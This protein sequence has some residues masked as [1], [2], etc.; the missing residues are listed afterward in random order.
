[1]ASS[2]SLTGPYPT[3]SM[4][5]AILMRRTYN[6]PLNEEGTKFETFEETVDR[7]IDHQKWLWERAQGDSLFPDQV[8]EL[9]ELKEHFMHR[10]VA[11]A[12]RTLW[13]GGTELAKRRESSQ[14][15]CLGKETAFITSEGVRTFEDCQD[16]DV[17]TVLSH[18]GAWRKAVVRCYGQQQLN[19]V[20]LRRTRSVQVIRATANH[21]WILK[22]GSVTDALRTGQH[23]AKPVSKF[24][25]WVYEEAPPAERLYWAYGFVY[26]D[27]T[28]VRNLAGEPERSM[29]RMCGPHKNYVTRFEELGFSTSRP[30]S[31][32]GDPFAYTGTYLKTLPDLTNDGVDLVRAF[33]RGYLDAD[34]A[35]NNSNGK[36]P[37]R[38]I[39]ATGDEAIEFIRK[40]FPAVGVFIS[41]EEVIDRDTNFGPRTSQTIRFS[42]TSGLGD[43]FNSA[44]SVHSIEPDA[45][46]E[47]WCLE[48]EE[49]RSFTLANGI[50]TGNCS[51]LD[52]RTVHDVVDAFWLLLQGCG[53]GFRPISGTLSGFTRK[54]AVEVIR[55]TRE[56]KG[57]C[58]TNRETYDEKTGTWTIAVGD[59]AEAW[60]K[61]IGKM[62]AGKFPAKKLVLDL[63]QIRVP[64]K[65]LKGYGWICSGDAQLAVALPEI[66]AILN[67]RTGKLLT[68]N[69]ITDMVNWLGTVLSNRRSAQIAIMD[70]GDAEWREFASR[71]PP[72]FDT[73][74]MWFRGQSN[75]TLAFEERPSRKQLKDV[76][77]LMIANGGSEPGFLNMAAARQ[78]AP[79]IRGLNPCAEILLSSNSFCCLTELDVAPFKDDDRAMNRAAWLIARANYRQTLVNLNDGM[80]QASWHQQNEY[81]RLCGVSL[82]GVARRPDL[83]A[84]DYRQ[85]RY[86]AITGAYNM[87]DELGLERPK[88]VTTVKPSGTLSKAW[89]L[90]TTEGAHKPKARY[91]FNNVQFGRLDPLVP[92]LV[93]AGYRVVDHPYDPAA[94][95]VTLPVSYPDVP[96]DLWNGHEVDRESAVAQLERYRLLNT[97]WADQNV[98]ITVS[99]DPTEIDAIVDWLLRNWDDYVA[100]SWL[101]R[102][103]PTKTAK[104][105]GYAYLPQEVVTK[106]TYDEYVSRIRLFD[107]D[108]GPD[109]GFHELDAG[110][111]CGTGGCPVR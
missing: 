64:G 29:V 18:T 44:Y 34:G 19:R 12:G 74:G 80:L 40:V 15:N 9:A 98:S 55:S 27:G 57:G 101:F 70:Y 16:G 53:V 22:D 14:F 92:R 25:D 20:E 90:D 86:S 110:A 1:M 52:I 109:S 5:S 95:L 3:P 10:L 66:A 88:N 78:K 21:R 103:D 58:E 30:Q 4:R 97:A 33:V 73:S 68:K 39:Q 75:N 36:N 71:K 49:D 77:E 96:L 46:E 65:R 38:S 105:L 13:L 56:D 79:W 35:R 107:I 85:L 82:T 104:D 45:V 32:G 87:A 11:P 7:V 2:D 54:M 63:S 99:W 60:A 47:V 26:G 37:F 102:N 61:S 48:V 108:A 50:V 23:I 111:E 6:R 89:F 81:L 83:T 67:R 41:N 28:I 100:V 24:N 8:T 17:V 69:D 76:F 72:G 51:Y 59:S 106:E 94:V 43:S 31:C 91:I 62:I 84:W 93:D 42:L